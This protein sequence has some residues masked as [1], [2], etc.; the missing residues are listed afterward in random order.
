MRKTDRKRK[1]EN[2]WGWQDEIQRKSGEGVASTAISYLPSG[3]RYAPDLNNE[4]I[5][6]LSSPVSA[7][8]EM[9]AI[10]YARTEN[11]QGTA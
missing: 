10:L 6:Q 3:Y 4:L 1:K 8:K 11:R 2:G 9:I 5:S 7:L